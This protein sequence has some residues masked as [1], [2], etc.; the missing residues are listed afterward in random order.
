MVILKNFAHICDAAS[1]KAVNQ[2]LKELFLNMLKDN[3]KCLKCFKISEYIWISIE[4]FSK[5]STTISNF[6]QLF[7]KNC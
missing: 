2:A 7:I 4:T 1:E 5:N 3:S 6:I